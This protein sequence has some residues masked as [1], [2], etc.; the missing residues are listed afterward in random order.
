MYPFSYR[1]FPGASQ[2]YKPKTPLPGAQQAYI[3]IHT[4]WGAVI[5]S[6]LSRNLSNV[7]DRLPAMT[8]IAIR[9]REA[10]VQ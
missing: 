5:E 6:F 4:A 10:C 3:D 9:Y 2:F 7:E 1:A 8:G